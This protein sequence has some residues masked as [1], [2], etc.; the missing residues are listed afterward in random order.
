[1]LGNAGN[2]VAFS[3]LGTANSAANNLV[4]DGGNFQYTG[5]GAVTDR[6]FS[7]TSNGGGLDA[8]STGSQTLNF[9][10]GAPITLIDVN[11][12]V[13]QILTLQG[14]ASGN[15]IFAGQ[16]VDAGPYG[17]TNSGQTT[18]VKL[19]SGTWMLTN[20]NNTYSGDTSIGAGILRYGL[21]NAIPYGV[22]SGS[23]VIAGGKLDLNGFS[24]IING[25]VGVGSVDNMSAS[26]VTL[27][28]G[29]MAAATPIAA[30][31]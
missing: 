15:N 21:A 5:T 23:V 11:A 19:G 10:N 2:G 30:S 18:L 14:T 1:M 26:P 24:S 9:A 29:P 4:L 22:N 8:S 6:L 25:L 20:T 27:T 7:L 3:T 31:L 13:G 28:E 17:A 12:S 16:I